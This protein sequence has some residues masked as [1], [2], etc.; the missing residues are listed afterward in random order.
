MESKHTPG[1]WK[2][3]GGWWMCVT[4]DER[5][6]ISGA[7][8]IAACRQHW[9]PPAQWEANAKLIAAAPELL[10][11]CRELLVA[12]DEYEWSVDDAPT[13]EHRDIM[14]RAMAAVEKATASP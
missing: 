3:H 10:T 2:V 11:A 5:I 13:K 8:T 7:R 4:L 14:L 12:M 9:I 1:P 6:P